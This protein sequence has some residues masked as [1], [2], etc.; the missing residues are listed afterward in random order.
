M[1]YLATACVLMIYASWRMYSSI[2][3]FETW[4]KSPGSDVELKETKNYALLTTLSVLAVFII[5]SPFIVSLTGYP[6]SHDTVLTVLWFGAVSGLII[7]VAYGWQSLKN[8]VAMHYVA[9]ISGAI[10]MLIF[11]DSLMFLSSDNTGV[12][13]I[14]YL[15][16]I[17]QIENVQCDSSV[18]LV[19]VAEKGEPTEWR[20][21]V[22]FI[23][24]GNSSK[25]FIPWP[26][27]TTGKS[28]ELTTAIHAM[29]TE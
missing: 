26:T 29:M 24:F 11:A 3:R 23:M 8:R 10:I 13:N 14:G 17:G 27:Y 18:M 22:R 7:T 12:L 19:N 15:N 21:P 9:A 6:V 25:P 4:L 1:L 5:I 2:A 28:V 20:C 16:S